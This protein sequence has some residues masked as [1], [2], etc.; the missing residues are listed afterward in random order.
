LKVCEKLSIGGVPV[1]VSPNIDSDTAIT[2]QS[3]KLGQ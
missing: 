1:D 3:Q 2:G